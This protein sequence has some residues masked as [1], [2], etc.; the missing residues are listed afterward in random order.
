MLYNVKFY[1]YRKCAINAQFKNPGKYRVNIEEVQIFGKIYYQ[2][3]EIEGI[4]LWR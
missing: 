3:T 4:P 1:V 2:I